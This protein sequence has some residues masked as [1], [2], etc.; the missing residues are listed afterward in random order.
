[1][2]E[3]PKVRSVLD[4]LK[5]RQDAKPIGRAHYN[6]SSDRTFFRRKQQA[7]LLALA[8]SGNRK[9]TQFFSAV[10]TNVP[11]DRDGTVPSI[12]GTGPGPSLPTPNVN[13]NLTIDQALHQLDQTLLFTNNQRHEKRLLHLTKYDFMRLMCVKKFL[14]LQRGDGMLLMQA[15]LTVAKFFLMKKEDRDDERSVITRQDAL[16]AGASSTE[17]TVSYRSCDKASIRSRLR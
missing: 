6:G 17:K 12:D 2:F 13:R 4:A 8:S 14:E 10:G 1:V 16:G 3:Q 5:W 7:N 11:V 9:I 15:S